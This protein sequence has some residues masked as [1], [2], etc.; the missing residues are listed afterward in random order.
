MKHRILNKEKLGDDRDNK[1]KLGDDRDSEGTTDVR[2]PRVVRQTRSNC[3]RISET[4]GT[5]KRRSGAKDATER[6]SIHVDYN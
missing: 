5:A 4:L 2:D 3:A 6:P 1:E